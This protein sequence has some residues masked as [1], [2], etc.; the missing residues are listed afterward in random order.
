MNMADLESAVKLDE[1][2]KAGSD[3]ITKWFI[4]VS[5]QQDAVN[6][7]KAAIMER[8]KELDDREMAIKV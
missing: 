4:V 8:S 2:R 5:Q 1:V 7:D 3:K 6:K